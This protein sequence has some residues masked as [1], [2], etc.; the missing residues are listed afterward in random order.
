MKKILL[1]LLL[2]FTLISLGNAQIIVFYDWNLK[3]ALLDNGVD[4]DLDGEISFDEASMVE[5]LNISGYWIYDVQEL[6][7]FLNLQDLNCSNNAISSL[8]FLPRLKKL[9]CAGNLLHSLDIR[10]YYEL[11]LLDCSLNPIN[12]LKIDNLSLA[13]L[14]CAN[15]NITALYIENDYNLTTLDISYNSKLRKV[16]SSPLGDLKSRITI[17][18]F[19]S[20]Y[21]SYETGCCPLYVD[22][23]SSNLS[24]HNSN[25]GYIEVTS[26]DN[27]SC[28][29]S[30]NGGAYQSIRTF[31]NLSSGEYTIGVQ[32]SGCSQTF[33]ILIEEP[34]SPKLDLGNDTTICSYDNL[35]I[36][37]QSGF[38]S[39][40]WSNGATTPTITVNQSGTYSV[41]VNDNTGCLQTDEI[42]V[43]FVECEK[44]TSGS[45]GCGN[46]KNA[47]SIGSTSTE[48]YPMIALGSSAVYAMAE[49]ASSATVYSDVNSKA[50]QGGFIA[51]FNTNGKNE[52]I[53][54]VS[55]TNINSAGTVAVDIKD[56]VYVAFS[57]G[58]SSATIAGTTITT[59]TN[60]ISSLVFAKLNANGEVQW[61]K[62]SKNGGSGINIIK[63]IFD[64]DEN[65]YLLG[66]HYFSGFTFDNQLT[67]N[68]Q[69]GKGGAF[70]I[71]LD[72]DGNALWGANIENVLQYVNADI[73]IDAVGNI[74]VARTA[75]NGTVYISGK[76]EYTI[77]TS[78]QGEYNAFI[79][80]FDSNGNY[81]YSK[82]YGGLRDDANIRIA[83][84][85]NLDFYVT[86]TFTV[87]EMDIDG[88][89]ITSKAINS[90]EYNGILYA[91]F[92]QAGQAIWA[93]SLSSGLYDWSKDLIVKDDNSIYLSGSAGEGFHY[94]D[95]EL[96]SI[97]GDFIIKTN[98]DGKI[99]WINKHPNFSSFR[100]GSDN[101][102]YSIGIFSNQINLGDKTL[103]SI[104]DRDVFIS[105]LEETDLS[106]NAKYVYETCQ[107]N[108]I[109]LDAGAQSS[110]FW[111]VSNNSRFYTTNISDTILLQVIDNNGC[112]SSVDSI[113]TKVLPQPDFLMPKDTIV[114]CG[115]DSV[116]IS[117][118][119]GFSDYLWT[120]NTTLPYKSI[121]SSELV[122]V[123]VLGS[124]G[125]WSE[126]KHT[127]VTFATSVTNELNISICNGD[128]ILIHNK[129][130][131]SSGTY[132][133]TLVSSLGCDS[134]V[135]THLTVNPMF[136]VELSESICQGHSFFWEGT[137]YTTQGDY[138]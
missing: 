19:G 118:E 60:D 71:K 58:V 66:C 6:E 93:K 101:L 11:Q 41:T 67:I 8:P 117:I 23:A 36:N 113:I 129:Y 43:K 40:L 13:E 35:V 1:L 4:T 73:T 38:S 135:T 20:P 76:Q 87:P 33:T 51:K 61:I 26:L 5:S 28:L 39:Y 95:I 57:S 105:V 111:S 3:T 22:I 132:I 138:T 83:V 49:M 124:N 82:S 107:P 78:S 42:N 85:K 86:S 16:C 31:S 75:R 100:I 92:N 127:N 59:N 89:K 96:P 88:I 64:K 45:V 24:C 123:Q 46:F 62:Q 120:D 131:Y 119:E 50:C 65:M 84:D 126:T 7:Y 27:S 91:K 97:N 17:N 80:K 122:E 12:V 10:N 37:A 2:F 9:Y 98:S 70:L 136:N 125:C 94:G 128:S 106:Q 18:D 114:H 32:S 69:N 30:L 14:N 116:L 99:T 54:S 72:S 47:M 115:I 133:D 112:L 15:T 63:I 108:S 102:I 121:K 29:Y 130:K 34:Y 79:S 77:P 44:I 48:R 53:E 25:D 55:S 81:L 109:R 74:Y 104:G 103:N 134:I 21:V 68:T 90:S 110:Y 56:N 137:N 52:W